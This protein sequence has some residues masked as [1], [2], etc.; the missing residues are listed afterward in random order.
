[1]STDWKDTNHD[2]SGIVYI[3]WLE[4]HESRLG[5]DCLC[6]PI[7]RTQVMT[8]AGLPMSTNWKVTS[9][10][11]GGIAYVRQLERRELRF[12][13]R[14]CRSVYENDILQ[15]GADNNWYIRPCKDLYW[16]CSPT[17]QPPWLDC[18]QLRLSLHLQVLV[19]SVPL[20]SS[21]TVTAHAFPRYRPSFQIQ[22]GI[23]WLHVERTVRMDLT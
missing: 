11:L 15:A 20:P 13:S 9:Y 8:W 17:P 4:G 3:Y 19:P 22:L 12:N 16:L 5:R 7:G 21:T 1:M 23:S 10:N 2:L 6:L 18:Q 14:H